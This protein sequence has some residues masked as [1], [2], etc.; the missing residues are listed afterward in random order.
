MI[1][2]SVRQG[3]QIWT[4][5]C[6][7]RHT[8]SRN[9]VVVH[10]SSDYLNMNCN[11]SVTSN[12]LCQTWNL[13][14]FCVRDE[15]GMCIC[16]PDCRSGQ[17]WLRTVSVFYARL[18]CQDIVRHLQFGPVLWHRLQDT[19]GPSVASVSASASLGPGSVSF[20]VSVYYVTPCIMYTL[21]SENSSPFVLAPIWPE[22]NRA[23]GSTE[24]DVLVR[25]PSSF[26]IVCLKMWALSPQNR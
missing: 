15:W 12:C 14:F 17:S 22:V 8:T 24:W 6:R 5:V 1:V 25:C 18:F 10:S 20:S 2:Y 4:A 7:W 11:L 3:A 16:V 21:C 13:A 19:C 9:A 26:S 23:D